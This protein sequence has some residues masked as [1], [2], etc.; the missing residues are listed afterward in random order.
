MVCFSINRYSVAGYSIV[1]A[2]PL[3]FFY[4]SILDHYRC[5]DHLV[6][7]LLKKYE[8]LVWPIGSLAWLLNL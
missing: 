6:V 1:E 5:D 8:A 3:F 2:H 7:K 4:F